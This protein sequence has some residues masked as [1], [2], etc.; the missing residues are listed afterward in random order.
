MIHLTTNQ[1][2]QLIDGTLDY[3]GQAQCASHLAICERCRKEIELQKSLTKALQR[4]NIVETTP[5]FVRGVMM[6][7]L[8]QPKKS[9]KSRAVDNLGNIF[10]M[11]TVLAVLGYAILNPSL[12]TSQQQTS[13][14]VLIPQTVSETYDGFMRDVSRKARVV[15]QQ[16]GTSGGTESNSVIS[17]TLVSLVIL[18]AL[19][20]FVLKKHLGMKLKR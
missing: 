20:Q 10:G 11:A 2:L 6:E 17:F 13:K 8:P 5:H 9:W 14:Q 3:A 12:F 16:W 18:V 7:I 1:I 4:Q 15:L 19:D